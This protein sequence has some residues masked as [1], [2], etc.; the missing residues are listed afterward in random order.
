MSKA[1]E[2]QAKA[3]QCDERA[4]KTRNPENREWRMTLARVYRML[5]EAEGEVATRRLLVVCVEKP[6]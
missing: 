6:Q 5:A 3:K 2:Y 4:K 1:R